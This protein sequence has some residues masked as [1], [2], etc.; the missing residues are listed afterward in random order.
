M[1]PVLKTELSVLSEVIRGVS[2]A[3]A[4]VN[5]LP[6][7]GRWSAQEV[8]EHLVLTYE[9]TMEELNRQFGRGRALRRKRGPLEVLLRLQT[10]GLGH[11]PR[12]VPAMLRVR[13][14]N[15]RA[16]GGAVLAERLLRKA[17]EMDAL[18]VQAREKFGI[19]PCAEHPFYGGLRVDEWRRYHA[20]HARHHLQQLREAIAYARSHE[21]KGL[22]VIS[23]MHESQLVS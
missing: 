17:E 12:G 7:L 19:Q 8:I 9:M 20:I 21:A 1:H 2:A 22:I 3:E 5:P 14:Q 18:L 10:I 13:P 11:L 15:Y 6:G 23:G 4:Q 16:Q